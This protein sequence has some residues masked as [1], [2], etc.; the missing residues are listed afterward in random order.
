[1][2]KVILILLIII[3]FSCGNKN[4]ISDNKDMRIFNTYLLGDYTLFEGVK[5][6]VTTVFVIKSDL[7]K[8]CYKNFQFLIS[9]N[10][11]QIKSLRVQNDSVYFQYS[12]YDT[13]KRFLIRLSALPPNHKEVTFI[14]TYSKYPFYIDDCN[15]FK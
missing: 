10:L 13:N 8:K 3:N 1:M 4:I 7:L 9:E 5:V 12:A 2:K 14:N 11:K 6:K 15:A